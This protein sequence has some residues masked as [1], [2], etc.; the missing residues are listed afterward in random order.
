M[1]NNFFNKY[2]GRRVFG[3]T[4]RLHESGGAGLKYSSHLKLLWFLAIFV[5][6]AVPPA[7]AAEQGFYVGLDAGFSISG[8]TDITSAFVNHPTRCDSL[9]YSNPGDAPKDATCTANEKATIQSKLSPGAGFVGGATLGYSLGNGLRM[10]AEYLNRRQGSDSQLMNLNVSDDALG[11]KTSEWNPDDF[12]SEMLYDFTAHHF[13]LNAY[14]DLENDSPMTPYLGAG[15]GMGVLDMNYQSKYIRKSDL[16]S[17]QWQQAASGTISYL[18]VGLEDTVFAF[19][20]I[21]GIDYSVS[22][23]VRIGAKARWTRFSGFES[24]D[25]LWE[26]IRSHAPVRADGKTPF[27]SDYD[28]QETDSFIVT[29]GIKYYL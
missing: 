29:F 2:V 13:F 23:K 8:D 24:N 27:T 7:Q 25:K 28:V 16:G 26:S 1:I 17:E 9:L 22:E 5:L 3:Y 20:V 12:P 6:F 19:Q 18:D 4:A 15:I 14:Y 10:E 21:G 11:T